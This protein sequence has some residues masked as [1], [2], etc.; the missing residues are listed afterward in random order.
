MIEFTKNDDIV[1]VLLK[2]KDEGVLSLL[3]F[4]AK[5]CGPC[6]KIAPL[7][8]DLSNKLKEKKDYN[9]EFY[10]IDIDKNEEFCDKCEIKSVPT[11]FIM[12]G[13]DLLNSCKGANI[14]V[15]GNI[16]VETF[17]KFNLKNNIKKVNNEIDT[18][19]IK[20]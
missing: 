15:I 3:Y 9:I 20:E 10:K 6:Q 8:I 11:F 19:N 1:K 7:M 12:N 5:W 18:N 14:E 4:T 2:N 16:I 17:N 13:K